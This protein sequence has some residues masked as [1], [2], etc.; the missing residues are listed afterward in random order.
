MSD[1]LKLFE[2]TYIESFPCRSVGKEFAC[3]GGDLGSIPGSG[4]FH[5]RRKWQP[6]PVLLLGESHEQRGLAGYQL[7]DHKSRHNWETKCTHTE[8]YVYNI[9]RYKFVKLGNK[10]KRTYFQFVEICIL[11]PHRNF[12]PYIYR[13][14]DR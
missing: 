3:N 6:T 13:K 5:W 2:T 11:C 7:W 12:N 4:S 10:Y 9:Y 8:R 1:S 14:I